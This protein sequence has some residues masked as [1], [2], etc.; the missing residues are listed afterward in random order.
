M[1]RGFLLFLFLFAILIFA[2]SPTKAADTLVFDSTDNYLGACQ[3]TDKSEWT[4]TNDINVT[5]FQVWY[6]WNQGEVSIPVKL[7]K[8]GVIFAE[9]NAGR[10]GCDPYQRQW[11]NA[12]FAIN[13]V[14][15][16]GKYTTQIPNARQC[17]KP[18]GTG[19]IRLYSS[20]TIAQVE[21]LVAPIATPSSTVIAT[22]SPTPVTNQPITPIPT[23]ACS[24][25]QQLIVATAAITSSVISILVCL[26]LR[27]K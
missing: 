1:P 17:L 19:A 24:C 12:D 22:P 16:K 7:Y 2:S 6:N 13:K 11:C 23:P 27:K 25:N 8:D 4:L 5:T 20:E 15:P 21:S 9:F 26:I 14:L 3:L 18:N 10:N